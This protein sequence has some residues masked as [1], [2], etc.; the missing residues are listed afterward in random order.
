MPML[1]AGSGTAIILLPKKHFH[2]EI[3]RNRRR[4]GVNVIEPEGLIVALYVV[5]GLVDFWR[6]PETG[7]IN[8]LPMPPQD[9]SLRMK[10]GRISLLR[11]LSR[12]P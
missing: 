4:R 3:D 8:L 2:R 9:L 10:V 6:P 7:N 5:E 1:K 11:I 12:A